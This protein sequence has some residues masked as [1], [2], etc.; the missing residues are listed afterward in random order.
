M[1]ARKTAE[2]VGTYLNHVRCD[3]TANLVCLLHVPLEVDV[4]EL[5]HEIQLCIGVYDIQESAKQSA[6]K[7]A[8]IMGETRARDEVSREAI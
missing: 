6:V 4:Q 1:L 3:R 7:P 2:N 8:T 5:K